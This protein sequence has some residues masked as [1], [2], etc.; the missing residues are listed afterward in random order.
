MKPKWTIP[1]K[2]MSSYDISDLKLFIAEIAELQ[3]KK[4][5]K[6]HKLVLVAVCMQFPIIAYVFFHWLKAIG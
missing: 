6:T 1:D 4:A 5:K 2:E 3:Y